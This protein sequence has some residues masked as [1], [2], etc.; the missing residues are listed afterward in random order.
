MN[1]PGAGEREILRLSEGARLRLRSRGGE[2]QGGNGGGD[3]RVGRKSEELVRGGGPGRWGGRE[4]G[5]R[6]GQG[7]GLATWSAVAR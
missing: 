4:N 6:R 1:A 3:R 5:S 7:P 2:R